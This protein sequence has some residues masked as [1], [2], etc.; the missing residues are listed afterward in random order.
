[1]KKYETIAGLIHEET[2]DFTPGTLLPGIRK[3]SE[4][5]EANFKTVNK[6]IHK[7]IQEKYLHRIRGKGTFITYNY[8]KAQ[9]ILAV[10]VP[11]LSSPIF[12][13]YV[14]EIRRQILSN[15]KVELIPF[16]MFVT[17]SFEILF[18]EKLKMM[19]KNPKLIKFPTVVSHEE[20][21][22][23]ILKKEKIQTVIMNDFWFSKNSFPS[24]KE[25]EEKGVQIAVEYLIKLGHK[26]IIYFDSKDEIRKKSLRGYKETLKEHGIK[27]QK[28]FVISLEDIPEKILELLQAKE[29]PTAIYTP[30]VIHAL[31]I[32]QFLKENGYT[33]PDDI[34]IISG[35]ETELARE[36]GL[37]ILK[38]PE[39]KM[40][41]RALDILFN[42]EKKEKCFLFEPELIKR[43]TTDKPMRR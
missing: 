28:R 38:Y 3:L 24:V 12:L 25:N 42:G 14:Q 27:F 22:R 34:S 11:N 26:R 20:S 19:S 35:E 13:E 21:I 31:K 32:I 16:N 30:Y 15:Y 36:L 39:K 6:A 43:K 33:I 4:K 5:Y 41:S 1:M 40:V 37:T 17:P 9:E 29:K 18:L 8:R 7:L 23:K 2:K 10:I